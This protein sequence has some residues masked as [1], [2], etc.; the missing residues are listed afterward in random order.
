MCVY[1]VYIYKKLH[2]YKIKNVINLNYTIYKFNN[3]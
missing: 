1:E 3:L 2:I